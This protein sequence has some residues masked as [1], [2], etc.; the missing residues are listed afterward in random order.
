MKDARTVVTTATPT[1]VFELMG[2]TNPNTDGILLQ[3][4]SGTVNYGTRDNAPFSLG[5]SETLFLTHQ[6]SLKSLYVSGGGT[7]LVGTF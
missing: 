1:S 6:R 2:I 7:L 5:T 4:V 3:H